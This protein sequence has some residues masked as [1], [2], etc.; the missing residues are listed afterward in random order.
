ML[1]AITWMILPEASLPAA[2]LKPLAERSDFPL[3]Y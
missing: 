3:F 2:A 1:D